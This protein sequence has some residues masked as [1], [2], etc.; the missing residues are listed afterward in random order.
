MP[1]RPLS[2]TRRPF[3]AGSLA[4]LATMAVAPR[5]A[6][7]VASPTFRPEDFGAIGDGRTDDTEAFGRMSRAL[8]LAGGGVIRLAPR[9]YRV[10]S[11]F[12][13]SRHRLPFEP[14]P[15]IDLAGLLKGVVIEGN[16]ALIRALSGGRYGSFDSRGSPLRPTMPFL[17]ADAPVTPY[18][19]MI[20]ISRSAGP[21]TIRDVELDGNISAMELGGEWG[22][23]GRQIAMSGIG[24]FD[25]T[26]DELLSNLYLHDHGQDGLML[27]GHDGPS[28]STRQIERVRCLGNGRQG[29][30]VVGGSGYR[31][32]DCDFSRTGRGPVASA[33]AAGVDIESEGGKSVRD[34]LFRR[35][36]FED[37]VGCGLVA[38]SGPSRFARFV[39]CAFTGTT[40]W[41]CW[42]SKPNF[43]FEG[44]TFRG[45]VVRPFASQRADEATVFTD[46]EF[47]DDASSLPGSRLYLSRPDGPI[48]DAG[49]AFGG[50]ANVRFNRC[51]VDLKQSATLPWTV[52]AIFEDC[53]MRQRN[54]SPG[55]PRGL[56]RGTNRITG[57][58]DLYGSRFE[59]KTWVNGSL[60]R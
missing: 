20:R 13:G 46:C 38:D 36:R 5:A 57:R 14:K 7:T 30:S 24:L 8:N 54:S 16:G 18:R 44:C 22:D 58:V 52:G 34:L 37:N 26:G 29:C 51:T 31:F 25:N 49:G 40:N 27:D 2:I 19:F 33:P 4:T 15:I 43:S 55:Y 32:I 12:D 6:A 42:P 28:N 10:G 50:G 9:S 48:L 47:T 1:K 53:T 41:A 56:Y 45:A 60:V 3:V 39:D 35:C 59:G 23:I 21:V 17:A 11:L